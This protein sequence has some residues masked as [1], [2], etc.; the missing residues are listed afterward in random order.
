MIDEKTLI[1]ELRVRWELIQATGNSEN[2]EAAD[3]FAMVYNTIDEQPLV[4][5]N[6]ECADC[7]KRGLYWKEKIYEKMAKCMMDNVHEERIGK[8]SAE[9]AYK[10][11]RHNLSELKF[12]ID[13]CNMVSK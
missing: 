1:N 4:P 8:I 7:N 11:L 10:R 9:R 6:P 2:Y 5:E 12:A 13:L 3:I